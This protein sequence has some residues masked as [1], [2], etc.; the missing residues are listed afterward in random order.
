MTLN[1]NIFILERSDILERFNFIHNKMKI[2]HDQIVQLPD[3]LLSRES[4]TAQRHEFLR[5][6]GKD[7]Y[8]PNQKLYISL[9]QLVEGSD[10]DFVVNTCESNLKTFDNFVKTL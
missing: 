9:K 7:Q 4:R 10:K 1:L 5:F 6:L 2:S 3:I 8:E